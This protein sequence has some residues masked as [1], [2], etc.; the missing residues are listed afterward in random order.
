MLDSATR[1]HAPIIRLTSSS[2]EATTPAPTNHSSQPPKPGEGGISSDSLPAQDTGRCRNCD[3]IAHLI[4]NGCKGLPAA[5]GRSTTITRY[6]TPSCQKA[7][8]TTHKEACKAA[9]TRRFLFRVAN[10]TK[11]L[12][13]I[14]QEVTFMWGYIK[15]IECHGPIIRAVHL[16]EEKSDER[17]TLLVPFS[18]VTDLVHDKKE[19]E[20]F[21]CH[22]G[23]NEAVA[24]FGPLLTGR[25]KGTL[26]SIEEITVIPKNLNL[27][28]GLWQKE[29][30]NLP[31]LRKDEIH[32]TIL[33]LTLTNQ[34]QYAVDL[35][36]AQ[37]GHH[38]ECLPWQDYVSARVER[39]IE[40]QPFGA[41]KA[42]LAEAV[43]KQHYPHSLVQSLMI[44]F[45]DELGLCVKF[46]EAQ[47]GSVEALL[48]LPEEQWLA[49]RVAFLEAI[50]TM[51]KFSREDSIRHGSWC[52]K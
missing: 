50:K 11:G 36:G 30:N 41:T 38:E 28:I 25:L 49:K 6:C 32:H 39:I 48:A 44:S 1:L 51:M 40:V 47:G 26:L 9:K 24:K 37:Y 43:L 45:F 3:K 2:P 34:E 21:L 14:H 4:C 16:D 13:Y 12:F 23:C 19:Q 52:R 29:I 17:K 8:W 33:R 10:L 7:H 5:R 42:W 46:W 15:K 22:L 18:T 35:T 31:V 20:A 27:E